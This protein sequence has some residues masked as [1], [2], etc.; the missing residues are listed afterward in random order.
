MIK[1]MFKKHRIKICSYSGA[2]WKAT[3]INDPVE[4]AQIITNEFEYSKFCNFWNQIPTIDDLQQVL[5]KVFP[6]DIS[7]II[8]EMSVGTSV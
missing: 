8:I 5:C 6:K 1:R 4:I 3:D 7:N 2:G